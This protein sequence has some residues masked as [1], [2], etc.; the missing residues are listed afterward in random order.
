MTDNINSLDLTNVL[1][2]ILRQSY[3]YNGIFQSP[4]NSYCVWMSSLQMDSPSCD[5]YWL[6]SPLRSLG[7][8]VT[9]IGCNV[10]DCVKLKRDFPQLSF[11]Y[12]LFSF[13]IFLITHFRVVLSFQPPLDHIILTTKYFQDSLFCKSENPFFNITLYLNVCLPL[14]CE[15]FLRYGI[16]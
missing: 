4:H 12:V 3:F 11:I 14:L 15:L 16:M 5:T 7:R 2:A 6:S 8:A 10:H 9:K 13:N 1:L